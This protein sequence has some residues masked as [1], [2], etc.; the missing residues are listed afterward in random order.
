MQEFLARAVQV[1]ETELSV[2]NE[3]KRAVAGSSAKGLTQ[4]SRIKLECS[5]SNER[6][7]N[8]KLTAANRMSRTRKL[9]HVLEYQYTPETLSFHKLQGTDAA[10]AGELR[11][12]G[13]FE[14]YL[15]LFKKRVF[16]RSIDNYIVLIDQGLSEGSLENAREVD[17][18]ESDPEE[19]TQV[20]VLNW[21]DCGLDGKTETEVNML[22]QWL[23]IRF[24]K[25]AKN[26]LSQSAV[27]DNDTENIEKNLNE[28]LNVHGSVFTND[29]IP[30]LEYVDGGAGGQISYDVYKKALLVF[31]PRSHTS[32]VIGGTS[33]KATARTV[34]KLCKRGEM[35]IAV[36]LLRRMVHDVTQHVSRLVEASVTSSTPSINGNSGGNGNGING[37]GIGSANATSV[38]TADTN[39]LV[40]LIVTAY[41]SRPYYSGR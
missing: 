18:M 12:S 15:V 13:M 34:K 8:P 20:S 31:W 5:H 2:Y 24:D 23:R 9:V 11:A 26:E 6:G 38:S 28:L 27:E 14:L 36:A 1:W 39:T 4:T 33:V 3:T 41:M 22:D 7:S 21:V 29:D 16:Q 32:T 35:D 19:R 25:P 30:E 10:V 37:I 40:T 17:I